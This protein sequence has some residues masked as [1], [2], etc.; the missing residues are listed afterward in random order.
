LPDPPL[1]P[2]RMLV[3]PDDCAVDRMERPVQPSLR[4]R[5][6][7]HCGQDA[8]PN[9]GSRPAIEAGRDRLPRP[10][11]FSEGTPRASRP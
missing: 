5:Q 2:G 1:G 6:S 3:R 11:A 4:I 8:L 7:L 10:L 9:A